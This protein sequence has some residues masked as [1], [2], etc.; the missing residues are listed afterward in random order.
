[1]QDEDGRFTNFIFDWSGAKNLAGTTSSLGGQP[2][3]ARALHALAWGISTFGGDEWKERFDRA[4]PWLNGASR[5]YDVRSVGLLAI[6]QHWRATGAASS[7]ERALRW[8]NWIASARRGDCLLNDGGTE[9]VHLWGHL[10]EAALAATGHALQRPELVE[11]ARAS[12]DVLLLPAVE[13]CGS[14]PRVL[15]FEVSCVVAGLSA[16]ARATGEIRYAEAATKARSWFEGRN[17]ARLPVYDERML[18]IYDGIDEG[19]VSRNSGAE[20]N[21]EGALTLMI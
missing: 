5:H 15:P 20:S 14:A 21:I 1:M 2:W 13:W 16:V 17:A 12:A 18:L 11:R 3:Q 19:Q 8:A 10:Q 4:L 9:P 6:L 7:A